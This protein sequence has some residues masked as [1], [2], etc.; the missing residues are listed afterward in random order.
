MSAPTSLARSVTRCAAQLKVASS[1]PVEDEGNVVRAGNA[2]MR[3]PS[4]GKLNCIEAPCVKILV[5]VKK[6]T[7]VQS[8]PQFRPAASLVGLVVLLS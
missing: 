6:N 4:Q 2:H 1:I 3:R 8:Y 5:L 7:G